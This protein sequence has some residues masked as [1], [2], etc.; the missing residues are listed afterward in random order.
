MSPQTTVHRTPFLSYRVVFFSFPDSRPGIWCHSTPTG[1]CLYWINTSNSFLRDLAREYVCLIMSNFFV[2][3]FFVFFSF[4]W[5]DY[6]CSSEWICVQLV[7]GW[8]QSGE[9]ICGKRSISTHQA[10]HSVHQ[11]NW[12]SLNARVPSEVWTTLTV[13]SSLHH[14]RV[15]LLFFSYISVTLWE[16]KYQKSNL[17]TIVFGISNAAL[18]RGSHP[19]VL[20]Y[21]I[22]PVSWSVNLWFPIPEACPQIQ[23]YISYEGCKLSVLVKH[24]KNIVS[25]P[26]GRKNT[27]CSMCFLMN[28][29]AFFF[30]FFLQKMPNGSNP[31][32]YVITCLRPDPQRKSKR[33][34]KVV[35]N[36][37][38]PTFNELVQWFYFLY[39]RLWQYH[40]LQ[41]AMYS[42]RSLCIKY[43]NYI[44]K[45]DVVGWQK[46]VG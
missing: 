9:R 25:L 40:V 39:V 22:K 46:K 42:T 34:T 36:N 11:R 17:D 44:S 15:V 31:D 43:N 29:W 35:R 33:K 27:A 13:N 2:S 14:K 3:V 30:F 16:I 21:L 24:L 28:F 32:A 45:Q 4:K 20:V 18:E 1:K 10:Q 41:R 8:A 5:Y 6:I 19:V 23:L 7:L 12:V 26:H 38:S 37:D